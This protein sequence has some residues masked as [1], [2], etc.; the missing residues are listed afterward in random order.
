MSD[1]TLFEELGGE[2]GVRTLVDA[3][4]DHMDALDEAKKIRSMHAKDLRVS[5]D[6]LFMFLTGW[7][8]GPQLYVEKHGHPRLRMRHMP[9]PIDA[10]ARDQWLL[11]MQRALD[12]TI[13]DPDLRERMMSA[14]RHVADFM[15]NQG[16][17]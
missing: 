1:T 17:G 16:E 2:E 12:D 7:T 11:C 3:F 5:R 8:G 10:D 9:F 13:E 14:F 4:Y 6:K 15:R